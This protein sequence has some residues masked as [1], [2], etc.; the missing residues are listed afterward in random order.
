M[1][2]LKSWLSWCVNEGLAPGLPYFPK[3]VPEARQVPQ[4]L[5]RAK[6][7]RLLQEVEREGDPRDA[8]LIIRLMLSCGLRVSEA[9]SLR[10]EDVDIGERRGVIVVRGGKGG[11]YREVPVPPEAMEGLREWL[12]AR[13]KKYPRSPWLFPE[14]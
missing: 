10:L 14:A 9:V 13:K 5:K 1:K 2:A 7:N 12:A 8:G 6:V 11:K 3:G 4:A